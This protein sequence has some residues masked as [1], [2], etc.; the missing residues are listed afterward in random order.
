MGFVPLTVLTNLPFTHFIVISFGELL[1]K[2]DGVDIGFNVVVG[3]D[4]TKG[5]TTGDGVGVDELAETGAGDALGVPCAFPELLHV[6][7]SAPT[8]L[9]AKLGLATT[10]KFSDGEIVE[11]ITI[12]KLVKES[13]PEL[14]TL[15]RI[16]CLPLPKSFVVYIQNLFESL[17]KYPSGIPPALFE[18]TP[19]ET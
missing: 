5:V 16:T 7:Q 15:R 9:G 17:S 8:V 11:S 4:E 12:S 1:F 10:I 14:V 6:G 3:V 13:P 18:I 19:S 2:D